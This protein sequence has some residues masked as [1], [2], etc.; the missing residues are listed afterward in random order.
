MTMNLP[1]LPTGEGPLEI[2][3]AETTDRQEWTVRQ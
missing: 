1:G 3:A 2:E